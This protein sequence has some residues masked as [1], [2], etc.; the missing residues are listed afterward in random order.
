MNISPLTN[1]FFQ[2]KLMANC[3][4]GEPNNQK[5]AKI[6]MLEYPQDIN[7]YTKY[8][9]S[10]EWEG[11]YYLDRMPE[12]FSDYTPNIDYYVM[13]DE[14]NQMICYSVLKRKRSR[15]DLQFI[16][17]MPKMSSYNMCNRKIKYIGETMLAFLIGLTK[18]DGANFEISRIAQ[19]PKTQSFYFDLCKFTPIDDGCSGY[20]EKKKFDKFIKRNASHT[21]KEIK[22]V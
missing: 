6:Y 19:R 10:Y 17:T 14:N 1:I 20:M 5:K 8:N 3:T 21:G 9:K 4:I 12:N 13:E 15:N 18:E 7:Y 22:R 16:E 11:N 2:K